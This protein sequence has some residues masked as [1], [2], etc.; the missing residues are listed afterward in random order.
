MRWT[1]VKGLT[2]L[3]QAVVDKLL[4]G[5]HPVLQVLKKQA[6]QSRVSHREF[7]GV[8]F[9]TD[10]DVPDAAPAAQRRN[11]TVG[12]VQATIEG[13]AHGAGFQLLVRG[14]RISQLEGFTYDEPW[15]PEI[16]AF[17]LTYTKEPR[18]LDFGG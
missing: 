9:W 12:D 14:S 5:E 16:G 13:L 6:D 10:F 15:P 11:F 2:P 8:G 18:Q 3:E 17:E 4:A 7:T 1:I